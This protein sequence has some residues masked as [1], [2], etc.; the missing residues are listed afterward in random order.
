MQADRPQLRDRRAEAEVDRLRS[1]LDRLRAAVKL[2]DRKGHIHDD[3]G[4]GC[5][6]ALRELA[7]RTT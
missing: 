2:A 6:R 1:D 5:V 3:N 4:C 7:W